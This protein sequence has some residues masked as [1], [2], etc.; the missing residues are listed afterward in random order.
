MRSAPDISMIEKKRIA[1][2]KKSEIREIEKEAQASA[3]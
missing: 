2:R 1:E 3:E